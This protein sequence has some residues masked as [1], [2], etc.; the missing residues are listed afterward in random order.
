MLD[1]NILT[2]WGIRCVSVEGKPAAIS[3][4]VDNMDVVNCLCLC[5]QCLLIVIGA[6]TVK[7]KRGVKVVVRMQHIEELHL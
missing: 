5:Y 3:F 7:K 4:T 1:E 2:Q 6:V